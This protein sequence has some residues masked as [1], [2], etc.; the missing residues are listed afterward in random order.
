M[1]RIP[2]AVS[3][4]F[5]SAWSFSARAEPAD[6][7]MSREG[8][9]VLESLGG[10]GGA[11]VGGL[12]GTGIGL[13]VFGDDGEFGGLAAAIVGGI[14][15]TAIGLPT[16][17]Y[18]T[19]EAWG[20]DGNYWA[21]WGGVLAGS[22]VPFIVSY[23]MLGDDPSD[24]LMVFLW[25]TLPLAGGVIGYELSQRDPAPAPGTTFW[26]APTRDGIFAGLGG[27]F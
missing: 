19:G 17:I 6:E 25:G 14:P 27:R 9:V 1:L 4:V 3:V 2:V 10:I 21:T 22:V 16:G 7:P 12:V 13:A 18:L 24:A 11:V 26:V 8:R 20:G 5:L 15:G 23:S